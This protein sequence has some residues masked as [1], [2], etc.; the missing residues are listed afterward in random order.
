MS[1]SALCSSSPSAAYSSARIGNP[2]RTSLTFAGLAVAGSGTTAA[3]RFAR[4]RYISKNGR[5][6]FED[7]RGVAEQG[8]EALH[9]L[10]AQWRLGDSLIEE[11]SPRREA[12]NLMLSMPRIAT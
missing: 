3:V 12:S 7:D 5:L 11:T 9:D 2:S 1:V 6:E 8:K 10:A 4:A